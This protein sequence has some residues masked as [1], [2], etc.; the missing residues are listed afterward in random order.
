MKIELIET[1]GFNLAAKIVIDGTVFIVMD[2]I[3]PIDDPPKYGTFDVEFTTMCLGTETW[4][5]IFS[6]NPTKKKYLEHIETWKYKAFGE[7]IQV[8]PVIVD[9]GLIKIID[10][11]IK[12]HD[13]KCIGAFI[14]FEIS[15]L[16][17]TEK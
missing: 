5:E 15:R 6:G 7:I 13:Q 3:S 17:V 12:T 2:D 14:A 16:G 1:E 4:E 11:P 9:C 8:N 10:D